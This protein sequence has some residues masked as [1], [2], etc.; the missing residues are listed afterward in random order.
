MERCHFFASDESFGHLIESKVFSNPFHINA[1]L[2]SLSHGDQRHLMGMGQI[3][4]KLVLA[5]LGA[6]FGLQEGT[7]LKKLQVAGTR[8][9]S[10]MGK[11]RSSAR[12]DRQR[13]VADHFE[14]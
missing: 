13:T 14:I 6:S 5:W 10:H 2:S 7:P 9:R 1:D 4:L 8:V 11:D 12:H 3:K